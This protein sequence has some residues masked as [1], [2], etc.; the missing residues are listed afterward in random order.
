MMSGAEKREQMAIMEA[1]ISSAMNHPNIVQSGDQPVPAPPEEGLFQCGDRIHNFEVSLVMEFCE[2]GTLR[3]ALD[4]GAY[5][6]ESGFVNYAAILDTAADVARALLHLHKQQV[7][8]SDLKARNVLLKA[9]GKSGRGAVA[10]ATV[11]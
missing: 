10:K 5:R 3:D 6:D 8:H 2:L 7:M 1:A 9:D 4:G 11:G